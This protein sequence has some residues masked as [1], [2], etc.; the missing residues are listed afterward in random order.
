MAVFF[1]IYITSFF[2]RLS[3]LKFCEIYFFLLTRYEFPSMINFKFCIKCPSFLRQSIWTS[4]IPWIVMAFI[5]CNLRTLVFC[6]VLKKSVS[7]HN[8]RS[9]VKAKKLSGD[10]SKEVKQQHQSKLYWRQIFPH[11][12]SLVFFKNIILIYKNTFCPVGW[13]CRIHRLLLCRGVRTSQ[14]LSWIW[15]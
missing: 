4:A 3:E 5:L 15:H 2:L 7:M 1:R 11:K 8:E 10:F 9:L 6:L 12:E 14:R 13:G